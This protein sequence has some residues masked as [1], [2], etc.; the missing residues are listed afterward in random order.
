[1]LVPWVVYKL[2][3]LFEAPVIY[4]PLTEPSIK[5]CTCVNKQKNSGS[6]WA[7][8]N[9]ITRSPGGS[10]QL[11]TGCQRDNQ[12]A[13]WGLCGPQWPTVEQL[14]PRW[15]RNAAMFKRRTWVTEGLKALSD[16]QLSNPSQDEK[17]M[18]LWSRGELG[19]ILQSMLVSNSSLTHNKH[20]PFKNKVWEIYFY[21]EVCSFVCWSRHYSWLC[22]R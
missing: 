19:S 15:E 16:P 18:L 1:M 17:E 9:N 11:E 14:K 12:L 7:L 2:R 10:T 5:R 6:R 13:D 21:K 3:L 8:E 4:W 22:S 20:H